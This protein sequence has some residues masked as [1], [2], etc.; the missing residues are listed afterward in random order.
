M[1][2]KSCVGVSMLGSIVAVVEFSLSV[3]VEMQ[4]ILTSWSFTGK[5]GRLKQGGPVGLIYP[6][7]ANLST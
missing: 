3:E 6:A 5:T 4:E 2:A 7:F 1:Y